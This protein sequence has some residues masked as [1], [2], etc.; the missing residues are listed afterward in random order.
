MRNKNRGHMNIEKLS[1][2]EL[3][4][5]NERIT[6][7]LPIARARELAAARKELADLAAT[8]GF[9]LTELLGTTTK[10]S[11]VRGPDRKPSV[12]MRDAKGLIWAGRGR[13]PKNFD[14]A[15]AVAA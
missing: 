11:R 1:L 7:A 14:K 4:K 10:A 9:P 6:A 5:I 15:T 13:V 12:K 8:K 2:A 3:T